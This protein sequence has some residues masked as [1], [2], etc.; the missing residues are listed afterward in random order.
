MHF[1][2]HDVIPALDGVSSCISG[3]T[4]KV[5]EVVG[6]SPAT[7]RRLH[8][9]SLKISL[10][11]SQESCPR[12]CTWLLP[13]GSTA[14]VKATCTKGCA[15]AIF[16]IC[17]TDTGA[18]KRTQAICL[19][20]VTKNAHCVFR[21][22]LP[23]LSALHKLLL[24]QD[25]G[26]ARFV[27]PLPIVLSKPAN[28]DACPLTCVEMHAKVTFRFLSDGMHEYPVDIAVSAPS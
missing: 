8:Q 11:K 4:K 7:C 9:I 15:H 3:D 26:Q 18:P 12:P 19:S 23:S 16:Y 10:V 2:G 20:D 25:E 1:P 14:R 22:A 6:I 24:V 21:G 13:A 28:F 27:Y 17:D 5:I